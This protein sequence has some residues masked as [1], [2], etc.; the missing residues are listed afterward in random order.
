MSAIIVHA[1]LIDNSTG[2]I[3]GSGSAASNIVSAIQSLVTNLALSNYISTFTYLTTSGY[4]ITG[5]IFTVNDFECPIDSFSLHLYLTGFSTLNL[6]I[7]P[8][9]LIQPGN[10]ITLT[11]FTSDELQELYQKAL[12]MCKLC[13]CT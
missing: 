5:L 11:C 7:F 3:I 12:N 10:C 4:S 13:N 6:G 2:F 1:D 8:L 9:V